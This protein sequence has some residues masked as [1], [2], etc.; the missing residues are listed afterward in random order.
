MTFDDFERLARQEWNRVPEAYKA[1]V[2]GLVVERDARAHPDSPDVYTLGE[3]A[4]EAYPSEFGG[5]DS[6]RSSLVLYY[7]SFRRLSR[8]DS[9]F[10]WEEELWETLM[11]ELQHHLESLAADETLLDLDYAVEQGFLRDDGEPF[12]PYY[13]RAGEALGDGWYRIEKELFVETPADAPARFEL[14]GIGYEV[15]APAAAADVALV[16]ITTGLP[17]A[18]A[19]LTLAFVRRRGWRGLL[20]AVLRGAQPTV[21]ELEGIAVRTGEAGD[22]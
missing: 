12:D 10:D 13:Y 1:G 8:L 16:A 21:V 4:T 9:A 7:G 20:R 18:A 22:V 15:A 5:P 17:D 2:D 6:I 14:D 19:P 11:H 3:C